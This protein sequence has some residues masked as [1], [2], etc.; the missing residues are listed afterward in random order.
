M[1]REATRTVDCGNMY[2]AVLLDGHTSWTKGAVMG[3]IDPV[4]QHGAPVQRDVSVSDDFRNRLEMRLRFE[5]MLAEL[6]T[7]LIHAD[8]EQLDRLI[9]DGLGRIGA[10]F[11]VDRAYLF[12]FD[13][14]RSRMS[15]THEWVE[16]G[17]S[18][19]APNLQNV[20][21]ATFPWL[22]LELSAGRRVHVPRVAELPDAAASERDEFIREGIRS[23]AIVPVGEKG[24]PSG[25]IGF[26]AVRSEHSWPDEIMLGLELLAQMFHNAFRAQSMAAEM[27]R[28]ALHDDLTGLANRKLLRDRLGQTIAR[29]RRNGCRAGVM[30]I[31]IDDFKL[32]NDSFGHALGDDLLRVLA[33]RIGEMVRDVDTVARLGGDEFVVVVEISETAALEPMVRRIAGALQRPVE[34]GIDSVVP[35]ASIGIAICP[36]DGD[37][38]DLLLR[39]ADAAMY[40]AKAEGKNRYRIFTHESS[41]QSRDAL[42]MRQQLRSGIASGEIVPAY[43][44]RVSLQSGRILGFEALARWRHPQ[45]GWLSPDQFLPL[46]AQ[47]GVEGDL[48]LAVLDVALRQLSAWRESHPTLRMSVN[49]GARNITEPDIQKQLGQR[50]RE[51]GHLARGIELEITESA[52]IRDLDRARDALQRLRD[53][54]PGLQISLDDFGSGYSSLN[55]LRRLAINTLK[56]DQCFVADLEGDH[57]ASTHAIVRSIVDLGRNL[58]LQVVAEGI[59]TGAQVAELLALGCDE[60]QGFHFSRALTAAEA[61]RLLDLPCLPEVTRAG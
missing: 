16:E 46:A 6:S 59:E 12:R 29:C 9:E 44:P 43:Q 18:R 2:A 31:D 25:F 58:G 15:N 22:M 60:G 11:G 30:L 36:D 57:T 10:L 32:V 37:D 1:S 41:D 50:L 26:D 51:A 19:E 35:A 55:Y 8:D 53:D 13:S 34:F 28:L 21:F 33:R 17:I 5:R 45:L 61:T 14:E 52:V 47:M 7:R 49:I 24:S 38:P 54:C 3:D 20:P 27:Q 48:D 42:R 40:A 56:I 39:R 4:D 23:I